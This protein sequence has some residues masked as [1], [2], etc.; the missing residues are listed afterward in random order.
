MLKPNERN[1]ITLKGSTKIVTDFFAFA[2]NRQADCL[3]LRC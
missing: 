3:G 1:T 2:V